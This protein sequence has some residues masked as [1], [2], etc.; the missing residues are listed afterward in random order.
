MILSLSDVADLKRE[1]T[2]R[3]SAQIH[4][5][6]SC[7][8]QCFTVDK[9]TEELKKFITDFFAARKLKVFFSENG[10]HFTVKEIS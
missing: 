8:G 2:E 7:G 9:P 5:H 10:E 1:I 3:F 6:D 4:F